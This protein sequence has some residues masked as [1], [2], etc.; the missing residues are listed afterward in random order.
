MTKHIANI[1]T[2]CRIFGSILL[3]FLP[4]FSVEFYILYLLCGLTDMVDGTVARKTNAVSGFG[5]KLDTVADFVF[6][7]VCAAKLL[8]VMNLPIWLW[9]WIAVITIIKLTNIVLG[10]I[11]RK[12]LVA[13]HTVLNK[14]TGL[15]LFLLPFTLQLIKPTYSLAAVCGV[16]TIAAIHEGCCVIK[17]NDK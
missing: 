6:M 7:A 3:L 13:Y 12:Q 15:M 10:F 9:I 16:A 11:C 4:V 2:S 1:L 14:A 8:P 5:S 17:K